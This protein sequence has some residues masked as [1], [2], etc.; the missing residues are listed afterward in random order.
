M[1][2]HGPIPPGL[3]VLH[4]CDIPPCV[5][6]AHLFLGTQADNIKDAAA[7][8]R[9]TVPRTCTLSLFDRLEI[10]HMPPYRGMGVDLAARYGV[11]KAAISLIRGG[12]FIGSGLWLG[13]KAPTERMRM[14]KASL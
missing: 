3:Q 12:R 5:N 4:R 8:Q 1:L 14:A 2:A 13:T 6:A 10:F 9:L 7:K 11:T